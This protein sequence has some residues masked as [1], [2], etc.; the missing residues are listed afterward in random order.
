MTDISV[1]WGG[2]VFCFLPYGGNTLHLVMC[3]CSTLFVN[4]DICLCCSILTQVMSVMCDIS[5]LLN[6]VDDF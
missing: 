1:T 2:V 6:F 3:S 4:F 5:L